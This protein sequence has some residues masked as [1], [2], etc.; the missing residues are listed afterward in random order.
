MEL[1]SPSLLLRIVIKFLAVDLATTNT[2]FLFVSGTAVTDN[3]MSPGEIS[4]SGA[5][6]FQFAVSTKTDIDTLLSQL[7]SELA[8]GGN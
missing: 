7:K 8:K 1:T 3:I 4:E 6:Q 5:T 2:P